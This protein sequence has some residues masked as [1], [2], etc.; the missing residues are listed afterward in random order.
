MAFTLRNE[1][2]PQSH[3]TTQRFF[4]SA[5]IPIATSRPRLNPVKSLK[6]GLPSIAEQGCRVRIGFFESEVHGLVVGLV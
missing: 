6:K 2:V 1:Y 3:L 4:V 5:A